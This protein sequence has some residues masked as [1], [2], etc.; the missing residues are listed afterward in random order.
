MGD[1]KHSNPKA[2]RQRGDLRQPAEWAPHDACW[3]AF[4]W[5]PEAWLEH[6]AAAQE[7]FVTLCRAFAKQGGERL[8]ILVANKK[9]RAAAESTLAGVACNLHDVPYGD[10]WLRDTAPVFMRNTQHELTPV[11]FGFNGWGGKYVM[12]GDD[13]VAKAV[14]KKTGLAPLSVPLVFEG[15]SLDVDGEGTALTTEQCLLNENRNP[16]LGRAKIEQLV[17]DAYGLDKL[18]WLGDGLLNDHTDGHIDNIARFVGP[19]K[20]ACMAPRNSQDPNFDVLNRI[21]ATLEESTDAKGRHLDVV[22]LPSVGRHLATDGSVMPASYLNFYIANDAVFVPLYDSP[23][24][25]EAIDTLAGCFPSR[26]IIGLGAKALLTGGGSFHC[27]TQQQPTAKA[28][29]A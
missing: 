2:T 26:E 6:L 10:V 25:G 7:E 22:R 29:R 15:G 23:Y 3:T 21:I 1:E 4:P 8:E 9:V 12:D 19:G 16:G 20:V 5:D 27:I 14:A 18:I 24:D 28:G 17:M 13:L 11:C